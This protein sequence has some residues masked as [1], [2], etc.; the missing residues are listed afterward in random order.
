MFIVIVRLTAGMLS[1]EIAVIPKVQAAGT[2]RLCQYKALELSPLELGA[3]SNV[4]TDA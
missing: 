3:T 2:R 1:P 4:S